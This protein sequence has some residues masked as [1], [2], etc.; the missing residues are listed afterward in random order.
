MKGQ[1]GQSFPAAFLTF[2]LLLLVMAAGFAV[3]RLVVGRAYSKGTAQFENW[4]A[5]RPEANE[6]RVPEVEVPRGEV[7]VPEAAVEPP[8]EAG[9]ASGA[10]AEEDKPENPSEEGREQTPALEEQEE[11]PAAPEPLE[12]EA[13]ETRY[14]IQVG[15][16]TSEQGARELQDE[17]A[18][19]GYPARVEVSRGESGTTYRVLTGRY[20]TEYGARKALDQLRQE[21][22]AG[23]LVER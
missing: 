17:L 20:R 23:F 13:R 5:L 22:F 4:P 8:E 19:D 11:L 18:H 14:A 12:S 16:F 6:S 1:R 9:A 7:H 3:G 15:V 2:S 10:T 21:G